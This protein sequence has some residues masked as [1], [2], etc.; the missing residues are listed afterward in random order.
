MGAADAGDGAGDWAGNWVIA[1]VQASASA[2]G[3][4][5][6]VRGRREGMGEVYR[7]VLLTGIADG[8][9]VLAFCEECVVRG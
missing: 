6:A 7:E 9:R 1:D 5:P 8:S 4:A 2:S 3:R